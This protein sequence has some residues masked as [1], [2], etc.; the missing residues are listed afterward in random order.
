MKS[1][2]LSNKEKKYFVLIF[3]VKSESERNPVSIQNCRRSLT[4]FFN[5][6][7]YKLKLSYI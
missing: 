6:Q 2:Y 3:L 5:I 4:S 7:L 1:N